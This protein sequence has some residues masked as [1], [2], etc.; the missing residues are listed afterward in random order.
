MF[1]LCALAATALAL[2]PQKVIVLEGETHHVQGIV[3]DGPSSRLWLTAVDR[4]TRK[5]FLF[6]YELPSGKRLRSVEIQDGDR[7]H[8]GGLD[9]TG[10]S[11]WIPVA[12]YRR[13]SSAVIQKRNKKTLA[14]EAQF[15][16]SD[17]IGCLAVFRNRLYGGNWDSRQIYE[18]TLNGRQT[19]K[20]D[21]R[22]DVSY[23]DLKGRGRSLLASGLKPGNAGGAVEFL[24][25]KTLA[26]KRS[27]ALGKTDRG[28]A[29]T[30]EGV[31]LDARQGLLYLVPEDS[32]SRLFVFSLPTNK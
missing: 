4:P 7:Y 25:P 21:R 10:D 28:V 2:E 12:E 26:V 14:L 9:A 15:T 8:P 31:D 29:Y 18:W 5:G 23:Q 11:L 22:S 6:E 17:H 20:R 1:L 3:V 27:I 32:P 30:N 24:D 13:E 19:S 16:V